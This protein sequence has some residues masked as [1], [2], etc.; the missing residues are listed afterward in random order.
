[1]TEDELKERQQSIAEKIKAIKQAEMERE[2]EQ[3][4]EE[5]HDPSKYSFTKQARL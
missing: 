2:A 3:S 1:M 5:K 4:K